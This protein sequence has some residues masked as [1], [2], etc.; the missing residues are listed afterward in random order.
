MSPTFAFFRIMLSCSQAPSFVCFCGLNGI[1]WMYLT[2]WLPMSSNG[3]LWKQFFSSVMAVSHFTMQ[4]M[5][6]FPSFLPHCSCLH[7]CQ[8]NIQGSLIGSLLVYQLAR[9]C[10]GFS[11]HLNP[12]YPWQ[13][14][15]F[16]WKYDIQT[17]RT[18]D[19][20]RYC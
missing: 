14:T 8:F 20:W 6:A 9:E 7:T 19:R 4:T 13:Y 3:W 15:L 5:T 17:N 1:Y 12:V 10:L 11:I 18:K 2:Q 16:P